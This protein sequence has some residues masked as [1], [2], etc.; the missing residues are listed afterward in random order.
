MEEKNSSAYGLY[1]KM[2]KRTWVWAKLGPIT[3]ERQKISPSSVALYSRNNSFP[4]LLKP[5]VSYF[6]CIFVLGR[7]KLTFSF[8]CKSLNMQ[9][10]FTKIRPIYFIHLLTNRVSLM[11]FNQIEAQQILIPLSYKQ[12]QICNS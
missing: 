8:Q 3:N 12:L 10:Q 6:K 11:L 2:Q 1:K 5:T 4:V 9:C 7:H